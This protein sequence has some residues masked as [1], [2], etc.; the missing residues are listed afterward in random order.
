MQSTYWIAWK[1]QLIRWN[2]RPFVRALLLHAKPLIPLVSQL[3]VVGLPLF[4]VSPMGSQYRVLVN[5]LSDDASL[6]QL[7]KFLKGRE[8]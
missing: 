4:K 2:M 7:A 5:T 3:M 6:E 8:E 1:E